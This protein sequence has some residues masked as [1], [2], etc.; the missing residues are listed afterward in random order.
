LGEP[1][2]PHSVELEQAAMGRV[3]VADGSPSDS[4]PTKLEGS[5]TTRVG[6][7][8]QRRTAPCL[9]QSTSFVLVSVEGRCA[10]GA[11]KFRGRNA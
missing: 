9:A 4:R 11:F 2:D 5:V 3:G 1:G 6:A 7:Y 10:Y 8:L